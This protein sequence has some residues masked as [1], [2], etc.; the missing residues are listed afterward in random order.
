MVVA[1]DR[2]DMLQACLDALHAQ[3]V[4]PAEILVVDN[5]SSDGSADAAVAHPSAATVLRLRINTGG[6]GGFAIGIRHAVTV[7]GAEAVWLMDDDTVPSET[8]LAELLGAMRR[9]PRAVDLVA[10]R[11]VWSDGRDHPLN[12]PRRRPWVDRGARTAAAAA[13]SIPIRTSSFVSTLITSRAIRQTGLPVADYFLWNDDFEFTGRLLRRGVGLLVPASVAEHRTATFG[14]ADPG[15]RFY[16]EIRNK[17]WMFTRSSALGPAERVVYAASTVSRWTVMIIRSPRRRL[18]VRAGLRGLLDG[19]ARR[20]R[21]TLEV[22]GDA[23]ANSA[24]DPGPPDRAG[25]R[26]A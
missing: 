20:P 17:I 5:A 19:I 15:D 6:A 11:V 7:M 23:V 13:G 4:H 2:R 21:T 16:F 18:L 12:T 22:I 10:S 14:Y 26:A 3:T 1:H 24:D 25:I 8:A 9:Y